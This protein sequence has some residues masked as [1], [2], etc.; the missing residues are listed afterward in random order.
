MRPAGVAVMG[1]EAGL[2]AGQILRNSVI[3][4][5]LPNVDLLPSLEQLRQGWLSL[6]ASVSISG[7]PFDVLFRS[8]IEHWSS[9]SEF[10]PR[11]E[12]GRRLWKIRK[13]ILGSGAPL[14][15]WDGLE[16]ELRDRRGGVDHEI[17]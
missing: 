8:T 5:G 1:V 16:N 13:R 17:G 4:Q 10:R 11:T 2:L 3:S 7:D 12:L 14:L 9:L 6:A 15:D